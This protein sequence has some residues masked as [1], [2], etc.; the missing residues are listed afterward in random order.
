MDNN[1]TNKFITWF[2][3]ISN[4]AALLAIAVVVVEL[5]RN[6]SKLVLL[7]AFAA[8]ILIVLLKYADVGRFKGAVASQ[9]GVPPLGLA[10]GSVRAF[11]A[12]GFLLG[13]GLYIY[14]ATA[15][16]DKFKPEIFT[17]LS[18]IIAAVVGFYFGSKAAAVASATIRLAAPEVSNIDPDAG[19]AGSKVRITNLAGTG[20][21]TDATVSLVL[22][23]DKIQAEEVKVAQG[24]KITCI[25]NIRQGS[26]TGKWDVIVTNPDGQTGTLPDGFEVK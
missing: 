20:F 21:K 22:G 13:L 23:T 9:D 11:L 5:F 1:N 26:P 16:E 4:L 3:D 12:F 17:A 10:K 24:T 6:Q 8:L 14:Y 25:L 15:H 2:G 19:A 7:S 18:S